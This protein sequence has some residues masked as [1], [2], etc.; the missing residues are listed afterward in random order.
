[1]KKGIKIGTRGSKLALWQA[2]WVQSALLKHY[3]SLSIE[4]VVIKTKG[5]KI[6]DVP[7]AKVGGKGLFVKEIE[8]ALLNNHIDIAV[9]SMKDM[10]ADFPEGLFIGAVPE[11]EIAN[12]V[13]ISK[14]NIR[15]KDL[16]P[17]SRIGTSSLRRSAQM[18]N[19]MPELEIVPLR[20]NLDTR[21]KKLN[22][23]HLDA[24]VLAAA[25]LKRLSL[26][27]EITEVIDDTII[28]PAVGQG[29][30]CVEI[31]E[32]DSELVDIISELDH[33]QTRKTVMGERSFLK[34][35]G[36]SCQVPIA[37][38]GKVDKGNY[39]LDG[40]IAA[41]DG[42]T[43]IKETMT[44]SLEESKNIGTR[45]ADQLLSMGADKILQELQINDYGSNER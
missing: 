42:S 2:H 26:E 29:A 23:E 6:L 34:R 41:V 4:I 11:R 40:L 12:D 19:F 37:A 35:L 18:K 8:E 45:L 21:L 28:L 38:K 13:L 24:I 39:V 17:G 5:D 33:P 7:L 9:H 1:M 30:L 10:P 32:T 14:D 22:T 25:G 27:N 31:R 3:P 20:G 44:G 43:V 16:K 36:G 15:L